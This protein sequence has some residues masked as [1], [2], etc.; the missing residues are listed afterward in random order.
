MFQFGIRD[1]ARAVI[2]TEHTYNTNNWIKVQAKRR[3][4]AGGLSF[5]MLFVV[6]FRIVFVITVIVGV[7][8]TV[9]CRSYCNMS[10][11][12]LS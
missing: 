2:V 10:L 3:G 9:T 6:F 8:V 4:R 7:V 5:W 11:S 1:E 12:L